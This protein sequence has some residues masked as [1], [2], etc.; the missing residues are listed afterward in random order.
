M[1]RTNILGYIAISACLMVT[2]CDQQDKVVAV[3]QEIPKPAKTTQPPEQVLALL[4]TGTEVGIDHPTV[5]R[6][7]NLLDSVGA[8][9]FNNKEEISNS[10]IQIQ[11]ILNAKGINITLSE[12]LERIDSNM[13]EVADGN[14]LDFNQV[15]A[16]FQGLATSVPQDLP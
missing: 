9:C 11:T 1:K 12:L 10:L 5:S 16:S 14:R 15:A 13:P 7:R 8:K 2:A 4:E 6:F 3:P